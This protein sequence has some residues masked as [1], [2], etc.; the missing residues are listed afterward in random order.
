VNGESAYQPVNP[1]K[2]ITHFIRTMSAKDFCFTMA[3]HALTFTVI[4]VLVV[5]W[6]LSSPLLRLEHWFVPRNNRRYADKIA[7]GELRQ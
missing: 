7:L 2:P 1:I 5:A 3:R 6:V 4:A